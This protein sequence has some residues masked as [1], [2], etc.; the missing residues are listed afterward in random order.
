M[1]LARQDGECF[2]TVVRDCQLR[3]FDYVYEHE[4]D[5]E[6]E[7]QAAEAAPDQIPSQQLHHMP[8]ITGMDTGMQLKI[9]EI[10]LAEMDKKVAQLSKEESMTKQSV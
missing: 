2:C 10:R 7:I 6:N 8:I 3:P 9:I 1:A 4:D 5:Q